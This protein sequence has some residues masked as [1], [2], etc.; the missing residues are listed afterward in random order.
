[1]IEERGREVE[2]TAT[3]RKKRAVF[4][5]RKPLCYYGI[6]MSHLAYCLKGM[7]ILAHTHHEH[8]SFLLW[9]C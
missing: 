4:I 6:N 2:I 3:R 1:M 5:T 8:L 9:D 7:I